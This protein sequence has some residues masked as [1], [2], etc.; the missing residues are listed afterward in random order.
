V[1]KTKAVNPVGGFAGL[2]AAMY[3][4]KAGGMHWNSPLIY[5]DLV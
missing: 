1:K 2:C 3:L 4:D 5:P